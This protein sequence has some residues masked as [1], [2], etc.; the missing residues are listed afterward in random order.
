MIKVLQGT[1]DALASRYQ[2]CA[3]ARF[4]ICREVQGHCTPVPD[5]WTPLDQAI[6]SETIHEPYRTRMREAQRTAQ[7]L[8]REARL[9]MKQRD[10]RGGRARFRCLFLRA[11]VE[12]VRQ[13]QRHCPYNVFDFAFSHIQYLYAPRT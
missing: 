3:A 8:D 11:H 4:P 9:V 1:G 10:C 5:A 13:R 6:V 7:L 2:D 12:G